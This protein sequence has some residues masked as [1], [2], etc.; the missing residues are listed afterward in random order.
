MEHPDNIN[1]DPIKM[2]D[3]TKSASRFG[4][5]RPEKKRRRHDSESKKRLILAL[6]IALVVSFLL[7]LYFSVKLGTYAREITALTV[8][9]QRLAREIEQ[10]NPL[11]ETMKQEIAA[12]SEGRLPHLKIL[13]FDEVISIDKEYVKNIVFTLAKIKNYKQYEYKIVLDNRNLEPVHPRVNVYFFDRVGIQVG[14][15]EVGVDKDGLPSLEILERGEIKSHSAVVQLAE[16]VEPEYF[17]IR[18]ANLR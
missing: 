16:D 2:K 8:S 1:K 18:V 15:S 5:V 17:M 13:E 7:L 11:L 4:S 3:R 9:E 14:Y 6:A 10:L 12:L